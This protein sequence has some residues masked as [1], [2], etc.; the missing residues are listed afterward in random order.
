MNFMYKKTLLRVGKKQKSEIFIG[1]TVLDH[2]KLNIGYN[3]L[4][5]AVK[6]KI[7]SQTNFSL[8][9]SKS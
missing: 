8:T 5:Q 6:R 9:P 1:D 2:V 4:H 7:L 3:R